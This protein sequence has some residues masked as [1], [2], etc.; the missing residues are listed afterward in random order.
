MTRSSP[1]GASLLPCPFCGGR[2][3]EI[4]NVE[5]GPQAGCRIVECYECFASTGARVA[6]P[7]QDDDLIKAWN[8][9]AYQPATPARSSAGSASEPFMAWLDAQIEQAAAD[10]K[11]CYAMG[12]AYGEKQGERWHARQVALYEVKMKLESSAAVAQDAVNVLVAGSNPASPA[13]HDAAQPSGDASREALDWLVNCVECEVNVPRTTTVFQLRLA[14]AK[15]A[16]ALPSTNG[17]I[18]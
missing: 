18:P 11:R 13:T 10:Q 14:K 4:F 3:I 5:E 16:L 6:G 2:N 17:D 7:T 1:D 15:E 9:R 12:N 8:T